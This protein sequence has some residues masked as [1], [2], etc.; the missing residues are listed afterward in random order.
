MFEFVESERMTIARFKSGLR[1][2]IK[3]EM[4]HRY[5]EDVEEAIEMAKIYE[6]IYGF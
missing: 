6:E 5:L 4:S 3:K 1:Y 2:E